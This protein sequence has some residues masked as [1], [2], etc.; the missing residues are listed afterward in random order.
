MVGMNCHFDFDTPSLNRA[1]NWAGNWKHRDTTTLRFRKTKFECLA[2]KRES[3][4]CSLSHFSRPQSGDKKSSNAANFF[5]YKILGKRPR[6]SLSIKSEQPWFWK[7]TNINQAKGSWCYPF[8][9]I[10]Y[11][12]L[13]DTMLFLVTFVFPCHMPL[14][15]VYVC[16][17][18]NSTFLWTSE[19]VLNLIDWSSDVIGMTNVRGK[20][21]KAEDCQIVSF[22]ERQ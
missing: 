3:G 5:V 20:D 16:V 11:K 22:G 14:N 17:H 8:V 7:I 10:L 18:Q 21:S 13:W 6:V 12:L 1:G 4:I 19:F 9:F 15:Q 2:K